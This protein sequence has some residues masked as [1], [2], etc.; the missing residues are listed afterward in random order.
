[1]KLWWGMG[2]QPGRLAHVISIISRASG[3][4]VIAN[5]LA[6]NAAAVRGNLPA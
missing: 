1:M 5:A 2:L 6:Y 4:P 3:A